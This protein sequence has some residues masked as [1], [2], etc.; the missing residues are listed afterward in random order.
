[1]QERVN[2]IVLDPQNYSKKNESKESDELLEL[3]LLCTASSINISFEQML[4]AYVLS[5]FVYTTARLALR[6]EKEI[7][8]HLHMIAYAADKEI[9]SVLVHPFSNS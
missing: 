9:T 7:K 5:E 4:I 2:I 1:M 3:L 8:C 6:A